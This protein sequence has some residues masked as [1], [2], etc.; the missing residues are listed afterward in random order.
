MKQ[1]EVLFEDPFLLVL[2]KPAGLSVQG[3]QG[4]GLALDSLLARLYKPR[5]LLVHRLDRDTSGVIVTAKTR[6]AA[7][8]CASLFTGGAGM[9]KHYLALCAGSLDKKGRV[10]K[11]LQVKGRE[12]EALT[13]YVRRAYSRRLDCSLADMEPATGRM[14]QIRRHLAALGRPILGDGKYG[15]YGLNRELKKK[16][17]LKRLLL[18]ALSIRFPHPL[19]GGVV[20]AEA[21]LPDHFTDFLEQAGIALP[22]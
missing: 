11:S 22:R 16:T 15:D 13:C 12:R 20:A 3:G 5:P 10:E 7:A 9:E 19:G 6:E 17:G 1:P 14:H 2:N 4:A 18:H 8:A 21:P